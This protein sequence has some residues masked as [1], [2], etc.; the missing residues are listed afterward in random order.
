MKFYLEQ[1][2]RMDWLLIAGMVML[3]TISVSFIYSAAYR[4]AGATAGQS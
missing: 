3:A 1:L 4:G 2:K